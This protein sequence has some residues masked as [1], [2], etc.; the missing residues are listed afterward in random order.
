M[1]AR[2]WISVECDVCLSRMTEPGGPPVSTLRTPKKRHFP[3]R[4]QTQA[5]QPALFICSPA[6]TARPVSVEQLGVQQAGRDVV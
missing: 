2:V 6:H 5:E 3:T 1:T 4:S